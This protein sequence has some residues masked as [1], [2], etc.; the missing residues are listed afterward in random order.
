MIPSASLPARKPL[1]TC[2]A[3]QRTKETHLVISGI[4]I[5]SLPKT[6]KVE[7]KVGSYESHYEQI[8]NGI[9]INRSLDL[10]FARAT[11]D[12]ADYAEMK[13]LADA[14]AQDLRAQLLYK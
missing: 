3:G 10:H 14:A 4:T 8:A 11:C 7:S 9:H 6:I 12:G 2:V 1:F 13:T 5:S